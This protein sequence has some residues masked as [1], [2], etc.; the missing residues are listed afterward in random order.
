MESV[1]LGKRLKC[2][3]SQEKHRLFIGNV[4]RSWG[5]EDMKK[6]VTKVGPGVITV[7]LLKVWVVPLHFCHTVFIELAYPF[8]LKKSDTH[9]FCL[10]SI[11]LLPPWNTPFSQQG[12]DR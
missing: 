9:F 2:S 8:F 11:S 12:M 4:P 5:E 10:L 3:T 1:F 7:E 6:V